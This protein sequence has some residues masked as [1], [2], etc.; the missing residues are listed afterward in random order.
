MKKTVKKIGV[1]FLVGSFVFTPVSFQ[2]DNL[3][4][5]KEVGAANLENINIGDIREDIVI[6][7]NENFIVES[8][9]EIIFTQDYITIDVYG[10]LEIKGTQSNPVKIKTIKSNF[11]I[12]THPGSEVIIDNVEIEKGGYQSFLMNNFFSS[13]IAANYMGAV[14]FEGG[15]VNIKGTTFKNCSNAVTSEEG[16]AGELKV[17]YSK[18]INNEYDVEDENGS[19]FT[20][21]YWD[22]LNSSE[23]CQNNKNV[24]SC[25]SNS[26]GNFKID[27]WQ[28]DPNFSYEEGASSVLFLPG[29]KASRLYKYDSETDKDL[30]ELWVPNWLGDDVK[31]LRLDS[32]GESVEKVF[33]R[34]DGVLQSTV[35]GNLY[36]S[37]LTDL[38]ELKTVGDINDYRAFAYDWRQN[39]EDIAQNGTPYEGEQI[40]SIVSEID[41]LAQNSKSKKVTIVAHSNGGLVAKATML[42]LQRLNLADKVDKIIF[43]GTP[44]MGTPIA[45]LSF[46]YGFEE[47]LPTLL[48]QE[49]AR[50]LIENMPGAYGLLP[51]QEYFS[52]AQE[53]LINFSVQNSERGLMFKEAYGEKID[54]FEEF[55]DFLL[56]EK[57]HRTKPESEEIELENILNEKLLTEA[58]ETHSNLD[59]WTPPADVE[60][61]QLAGW[62][63]PTVGGINYTEKKNVSCL[64]RELSALPVCAEEEGK[65][66]LIYEP[67]FISDGDEVVVT[68]SGLM[69]SKADNLK[70]YWF[71]LHEY[72]DNVTSDV[73]HGNILEASDVRDFIKNEIRNNEADLPEYISSEKPADFANMEPKIRMSLYSPLDIHLY[74]SAG[75]HTG[76]KEIQTAEGPQRIIEEGVSG[77]YY[78]QLGDRKY[79]GFEAGENI[80][81][82]LDGYAEGAYTLKIEEV[83]YGEAGEEIINH[84]TFKNL[85]ASEETRVKLTIPG[86]GLGEISE[87]EADYDGDGDADYALEPVLN[88]E[89][90]MP[91]ITPPRIEIISPEEKFYPKN[92]FLEIG[93]EVSDD[94]SERDKIETKVFLDGEEIEEEKID[95]SLLATGKHKLKIEARDEVDNRST[96]EAEFEIITDIGILREN[97][98]HFYALELIKKEEEKKM[99]LN[100]LA[101]VEREIDSL[102]AD[103][104]KNPQKSASARE[105]IT[106]HLEIIEKKIEADKK[107]YATIIKEI[108]V[109]DLEFIK[110]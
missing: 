48:S 4:I 83:K 7:E 21:N 36:E 47:S 61:I 39:V 82:K 56:A 75:N 29:I 20:N 25:L 104:E 96:E 80:E 53:P 13:A 19:D 51:S 85:P 60:V 1:L 15:N 66:T 100:N 45:T 12:I 3:S 79:V 81:I 78:L 93:Y 95:L 40:R 31:D 101:V 91:D 76:Y 52:R 68:P 14:H 92:K 10:R 23:T 22:D 77:S 109:S 64:E 86:E 17:N 8:G 54:S 102:G 24:S 72:N 110:K 73:K 98:E 97:I 26:W 71:D 58:I 69:M 38:E 5:N 30:D 37:F 107:N 6:N 65:Y 27:P 59:N 46:L 33:T 9:G 63:L 35:M 50:D 70:R 34:K 11:A 41:I 62:G 28:T 2:F 57:D 55:E 43:V 84:I 18:F 16:V 99:I 67:K 105:K 103:S 94:R 87:L 44:Q 106:K 88:G 74:D 89:V 90:T 32:E 108:I 42:E 49:K